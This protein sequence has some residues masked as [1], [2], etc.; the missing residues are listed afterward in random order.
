MDSEVRPAAPPQARRTDRRRPTGRR[1]LRDLRWAPFTVTT[2]A[3]LVLVDA[4]IWT[5]FAL[6][7]DHARVKIVCWV[8]AAGFLSAGVVLSVLFLLDGGLR[9]RR[10]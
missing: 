7:W 4:S 9:D 6:P 8:L 3:W 10:G 5:G 1:R 2:I